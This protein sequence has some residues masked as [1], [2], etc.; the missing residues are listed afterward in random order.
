MSGLL[1]Y[2][3]QLIAIAVLLALSAFF[4][5]SETA[6]FSLSRSQAH[7]FA[8]GRAGERAASRLLRTPQRL[9]STV[10][11]GNMAANVLLTS[12]CASAVGQLVQGDETWSTI[13]SIAVVW[14][15]L[16]VFAEMTPKTV[17]CNHSQAI[18]RWVALPL[19][20]LAWLTAPLRGLLRL[21]AQAVMWLLGQRGV[22]EWDNVTRD[23]I[24]AMMAVAAETGASDVEERELVRRILRLDTVRAS[25]IMVP[26]TDVVG[27]RDTATLAEAYAKARERRRSRLPVYHDD[28]D[29]IWGIVSTMDMPRWRQS[30][31][32]QVPLSEWRARADQMRRGKAPSEPLPVYPVLLI[33][34]TANVERLL[35]AMQEK[36]SRL[37]VLV[38]EHGGTAGILTMNDVLEELIGQISPRTADGR[39]DVLRVRDGYHVD[40]RLHLR[41]LAE[42]LHLQLHSDEYDTVGGF[43]MEQ[44]GRLPRT[45]DEVALADCTFRVLRM[46]GRR[47]GTVRL[48]VLR[49]DARPEG[50]PA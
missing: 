21:A 1:P 17:A 41:D 20:L 33:P 15:L 28:L 39:Q 3:P 31:W 22:T 24:T 32:L 9:L 7:R 35:T 14:P 12:F 34:E 2:L 30:Q 13:L 8:T 36:R 47:V 42:S 49:A 37:A 6:L 4:S 18:A 45:G 23:E 50:G 46:A 48:T 26:R 44:L 27:I 29:G 10:L 38:G 43:I 16:I 11:V 19:E 40:G 25:D 5:A